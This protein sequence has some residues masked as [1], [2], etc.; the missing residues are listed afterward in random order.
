MTG[1]DPPAPGPLIAEDTPEALLAEGPQRQMII[2]QPAQQLP[3]VAVKTLLQ[4]GM[5][6]PR[7]IGSIQKAQQR[8]ELF[9][10]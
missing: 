10:A 1:L 5:R 3:P 6:Q 2:Q 9:T 4:L 8:L 7:G